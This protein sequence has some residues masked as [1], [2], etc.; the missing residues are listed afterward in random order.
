V[1]GSTIVAVAG[2]ATTTE[3][4]ANC[5]SRIQLRGDTFTEPASYIW[6]SG[7]RGGLV[8]TDIRLHATLGYWY[9][10]NRK[11]PNKVKPKWI[12]WCWFFEAN[13]EHYY[14]QGAKFNA[15]IWAKDGRSV[16]PGAF[17]VGD[18]GTRQNC[19]TQDIPTEKEAWLYMR[20]NPRWKATFT[21]KLNNQPDDTAIFRNASGGAGNAIMPFYGHSILIEDWHW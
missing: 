5:D 12:D 15:Y 8:E 21:M 18:D 13:E 17:T 2:T 9:C 7:P 16:N 11:N 1:A 20:D 6:S 14:W 4:A 3:A 10:P 19:R